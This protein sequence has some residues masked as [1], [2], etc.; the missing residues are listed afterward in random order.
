MPKRICD[1][2]GK[3]R[4]IEGGKTCEK[5]HFICREHKY[6]GDIFTSERKRCPICGT[7]LR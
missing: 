1:V 6:T 7:A 3:E 2:D 4:D 5:G